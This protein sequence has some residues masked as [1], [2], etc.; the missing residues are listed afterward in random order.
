MVREW[1]AR[2]DIAIFVAIKLSYACLVFVAPVLFMQRPWWQIAGTW[3]AVSALTSITFIGLLIGTHF[4]EATAHPG[5]AAD[6]T[7]AG[8]W[9]QHQLATALDWNPDSRVANWIS[10]GANAHAAHHLFP[11]V[12]HVHYRALTRIIQD[13]ARRH[14]VPYNQSTFAGM[15]GSHFRFLKDMSAGAA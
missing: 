6:G 5:I 10:G 8:S 7:I 15:I 11:R 3:L 2:R 9:A 13:A 4:V 14:G 12:P 1:P